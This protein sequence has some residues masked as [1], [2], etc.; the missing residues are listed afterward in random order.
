MSALISADGQTRHLGRIRPKSRPQVL[1]FAHYFDA[2]LLTTPPPA[3]VDYSAKAMASL[4][5]MYRNDVEGDCVIAGKLH[6][7]G[8]WSG[9]DA[10]SG[11][12][13]LATD[14]EAH[15]QYV[16]ICGP[17]D[18]GCSITAVLNYQKANGLV[19]GGKAYKIDGYVSVDWRNKLEVQVA[20]YL[21][22]SLSFGV[23]LPQAWADSPEGG[24]WDV[25]NTQIVGGHDVSA[26]GY[27]ATGVVIA[28]WGGLR[29]ITW[30]AMASSRWL[31]ECY[32][33]LAPLWYGSDKVAP[34]GV[35]AAKLA[36]DL[37][38]LGGGT[39]P[40]IDP[41]PIPVPPVPPTPPVPPLPPVPVPS[42]LGWDEV[43]YRKGG[44]QVGRYVQG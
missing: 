22:G 6:Q 27:N 38:L 21:F 30:A 17:G 3:V 19:A 14:A 28:T 5:R 4:S 16:G 15:A 29:T 35:N 42:V 39:I 33:V 7:L 31:E 40:P 24:L 2:S 41:E 9:N 10:D 26:V 13:V 8:L 18:R 37:Q 11:G 25:T 32:A 12:I 23:N 44:V 1:A 34:C 20:L 36:A 43:I